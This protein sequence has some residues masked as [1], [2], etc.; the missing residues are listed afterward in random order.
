MKQYEIIVGRSRVMTV[1]AKDAA[2][3]RKKAHHQLGKPGRRS[4][5]HQWKDDGEKV[6]LRCNNTASKGQAKMDKGA[7]LMV[8]AKLLASN[9]TKS[10]MYARKFP[11][12]VQ[13]V[14]NRNKET[15]MA[16]GIYDVY[17]SIIQSKRTEC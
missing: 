12:C 14:Q 15:A 2:E 3:A 4:I 6:E 13:K 10:R 1:H 7:A 16:L 8:V 5:Y 11:E 9:T 17:M